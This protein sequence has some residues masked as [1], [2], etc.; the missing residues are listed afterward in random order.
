MWRE[1]ALKV[2]LVLGGITLYSNGLFLDAV[3]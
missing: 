3:C 1:R 2:V